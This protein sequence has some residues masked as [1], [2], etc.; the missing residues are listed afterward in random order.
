M[1]RSGFSFFNGG[2]EVD[3][4]SDQKDIL[5]E[6]QQRSL[7]GI[8]RF[9]ESILIQ[10]RGLSPAGD[11]R[12]REEQ[13]SGSFNRDDLHEGNYHFSQTA[14]IEARL[15]SVFRRVDD[16]FLAGIDQNE[17]NQPNLEN[18]QRKFESYIHFSSFGLPTNV[19]DR[20]DSV[21]GTNNLERRFSLEDSGSGGERENKVLEETTLYFV[22]GGMVSLD[23]GILD[24]T[25]MDCGEEGEEDNVD[26]DGSTSVAV[27]TSDL[28]ITIPLPTLK[29]GGP[30]PSEMG[31]S[32]KKEAYNLYGDGH[33]DPVF[34]ELIVTEELD[35]EKGGKV[36]A[37]TDL[38]IEYMA[39]DAIECY[40][41][42]LDSVVH[43]PLLD[44]PVAVTERL[45]AFVIDVPIPS[46][47]VTL[48]VAHVPLIDFV[49]VT[50][51]LMV[52]VKYVLHLW[53]Y[54][55][56]MLD[57]LMSESMSLMKWLLGSDVFMPCATLFASPCALT[58]VS[59]S[60]S[61]FGM[62]W[63]S[64]VLRTVE[65]IFR[66]RVKARWRMECG[67]ASGG[68]VSLQRGAKARWRVELDEAGTR[69]GNFSRPG[70]SSAG[71]RTLL[72]GRDNASEAFEKV[73]KFSLK[74]GTGRG[75]FS[76]MV[77]CL[78]LRDKKR[79]RNT[80]KI[81]FVALLDGV[82]NEKCYNMLLWI[83]RSTSLEETV[84]RLRLVKMADAPDA[85]DAV[86]GHVEAF[87]E[88]MMR[89]L[90]RR[91]GRIRLG[92]QSTRVFVAF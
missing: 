37:L 48:V 21:S 91:S 46:P 27:A 31:S 41:E 5:E 87:D 26:E 92:H 89:V 61:A 10:Q 20:H 9:E 65:G 64:A 42:C 25:T 90:I 85:Q 77:D 32:I 4:D 54:W 34:V 58:R 62:L 57:S 70:T 81:K 66:G 67:I 47:M 19:T 13:P 59:I 49:A 39:R 14:S 6:D 51:L 40:C 72:S 18:N 30:T 28:N 23:L 38:S 88:G 12:D 83:F 76:L 1:S 7:Q 16:G 3:P 44:E 35:V 84:M 52:F 53:L 36:S 79:L 33:V 82:S 78:T 69:K 55:Y 80:F 45:T 29:M 56:G 60:V 11:R 22:N 86:H 68:A 43:V 15:K 75:V 71:G 17:K 2:E 63:T 50:K 74:F 24:L 8:G 73:P